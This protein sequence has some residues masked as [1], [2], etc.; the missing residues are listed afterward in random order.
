MANRALDNLRSA[1]LGERPR[2]LVNP[3]VWKG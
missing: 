1:L 2:D 3:Q